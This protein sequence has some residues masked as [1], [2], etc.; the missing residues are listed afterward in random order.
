MAKADYFN[1]LIKLH[2]GATLLE[3]K[4]FPNA[5]EVTESFGCFHATIDALGG[6]EAC[7]RDITCV[8]VGDGT[9]PRTGALFALRT[10]W[11]VISI[12]PIMRRTDWGK[13]INRLTAIQGK[14][15]D[16]PMQY[17]TDLVL[18]FPHSHADSQKV[19]Q[20]HTVTE[21]YTRTVVWLPCCVEMKMDGKSISFKDARIMSPK[22]RFYIY[23]G[24]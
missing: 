5:K 7:G 19:L 8:V 2:C 24:V 14:A 12:D 1:E 13:E 21:G 23:Q 22:N 6:M 9:K 4:L 3:K 10:R 17:D 15:E 16:F 20:A 11:N 18:V